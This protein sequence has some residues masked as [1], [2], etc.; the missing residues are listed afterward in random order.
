MT[1]DR[2]HSL[3]Q[4]IQADPWQKVVDVHAEQVAALSHLSEKMAPGAKSFGPS[5][6]AITAY[7]GLDKSLYTIV[8]KVAR[9]AA[10]PATKA[11]K[12]RFNV[13]GLK[14]FGEGGPGGLAGGG[15]AG[16]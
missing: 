1:M 16:S 13:K 6:D 4:K 5:A 10:Q 14:G 11:P 9:N 2:D 12:M 15:L 8:E 7:G 3:E